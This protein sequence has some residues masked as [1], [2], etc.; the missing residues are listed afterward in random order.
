[1]NDLKQDEVIALRDH[2]AQLEK[3][4]SS[5]KVVYRDDHISTC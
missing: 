1:M 4:V 5:L 2:N 3:I